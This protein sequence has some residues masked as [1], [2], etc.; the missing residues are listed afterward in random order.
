MSCNFYY[1]YC[2]TF[3]PASI[4]VSSGNGISLDA[5]SHRSIAKLHMSAALVLICLGDLVSASGAIHCGWYI[6]PFSWNENR[7]SAMLMR[8]HS[9]SSETQS[10]CKNKV[11]G[12]EKQN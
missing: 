8:A 1:Y 2:V 4:G 6:L 7:Q 5:S 11:S 12:L 3:I 9:S 10:I